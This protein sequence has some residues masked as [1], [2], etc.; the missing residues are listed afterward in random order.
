MLE[1]KKV[2]FISNNHPPKIDGVGDYTYQL[3]K[4]LSGT[5]EVVYLNRQSLGIDHWTFSNLYKTL[6]RLKNIKP[7]LISLQYV[8]FG[9]HSKGLPFS[10]LFFWMLLKIRG[11]SLQVTFHEVA[12]G[13]NANSIRQ[14]FAALAQRIIAW[15]LCLLSNHVFTSVGLYYRMLIPFNKKTKQVYIGANFLESSKSLKPT[16]GIQIIIFNNRI[17]D[18]FLDAIASLKKSDILFKCSGI[19]KIDPKQRLYLAQRI[20]QLALSEDVNM[21]TN[22]DQSA[23]TDYL[24]WGDI[25]VQ[26]EWIDQLGNGGASLKSGVLMAA[27]K[28]GLP[29]LTT[30]GIMT[31]KNVLNEKSGILYYQNT[32]ELSERLM[33]LC[34]QVNLRNSLGKAAQL[35]YQQNCSWEMI[36]EKYL[37]LLND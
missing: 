28:A 24:Y 23:I 10:L 22:S 17:N 3:G 31:D 35:F 36:A 21:I 4:A 9:F 8:P 26:P 37:K 25:Y 18:G 19:G 2:V 15:S 29:V 5:T 34:N 20:V 13:F 33:L 16:L 30:Q 11:Y 14:S 27:M 1:K 12:I 7:D 32:G 6:A